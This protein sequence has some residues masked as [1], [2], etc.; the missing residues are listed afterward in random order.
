MVDTPSLGDALVQF[1]PGDRGG[2]IASG[3]LDYQKD[4]TFCKLLQLHAGGAPY[5]VICDYHE[6]VLVLNSPCN[7]DALELYQVKSRKGSKLHTVA[8]LV[9]RPDTPYTAPSML[10]RVAANCHKFAE[11]QIKGIIASSTGFSL[12][13]QSGGK[14]AD[15]DEIAF[16][17]LD[18]K[19]RKRVVEA[20]E[21]D[22]HVV[23]AAALAAKL[24]FQKAALKLEGH[25]VYAK[26]ALVEFLDLAYPG[27]RYQ[28][29]ALY[30]A[31]RGEIE[32]R[33]NYEQGCT[34]FADLSR[35]KGIARKDFEAMLA[36]ARVGSDS[37][38]EWRRVQMRLDAESMP[39]DK[40]EQL[41]AG[42]RQYEA[43]RM[44]T[45]NLAVRELGDYASKC[46]ADYRAQGLVMTL[47]GLIDWAAEGARKA[48]FSWSPAGAYVQAAVLWEVSHEASQLSD[49]GEEPA[50]EAR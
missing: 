23:G 37:A 3:R 34:S 1:K 49:A 16:N 6:D 44:D 41:K 29:G 21:R 28:A 39:W 45:A 12:D 15:L 27:S 25:D 42:W 5:L 7:P 19:T 38:P 9:R 11:Y 32:K 8:D 30:R 40:I 26:G 10:G 20:I 43:E 2:S 48:A 22:L 33:T 4:W 14:S 35:N 31:I 24:S 17:D 47:T 46:V 13:M 18:E 36:C 50:E